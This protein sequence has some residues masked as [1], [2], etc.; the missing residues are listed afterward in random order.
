LDLVNFALKLFYLAVFA[1]ACVAALLLYLLKLNK[2]DPHA[3]QVSPYK[4]ASHPGLEPSDAC[5]LVA[6][7]QHSPT[8]Q[9]A[10]HQSLDLHCSEHIC[11]T[12]KLY[13]ANAWDGLHDQI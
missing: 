13:L 2:F 8:G 6:E 9:N 10:S 7:Y 11:P 5:L 3:S 1:P 4:Q 12:R